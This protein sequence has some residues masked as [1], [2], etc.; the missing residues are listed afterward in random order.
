MGIASDITRKHNLTGDFLFSWLLQSFFPLF[1]GDL[2]LF[3]FFVNTYDMKLKKVGRKEVGGYREG[4][5][6]GE[7]GQHT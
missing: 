1:C 4:A 2:R 7:C 5:A 6:G 3:E